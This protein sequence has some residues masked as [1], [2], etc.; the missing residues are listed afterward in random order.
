WYQCDHLGTPMELT[1]E[2][3]DIA[4]SGVY[5]A[6][7]LAKE[8]RSETAKRADIRNPLRFQGQYFDVE[9]GL[10][11]NRYRYYD[12]QVGRFIGKDPIGF[13]GGL[14]VYAYA[15]NPIDWIDPLGLSRVYKDA[16]YHGA[17]D[18]SVKSRAPSNG[19]A[20]LDNSIQ[21][22][23]SSPRRVGVD[24]KNNELVVLDRTQTLPNDDEEFHGHVRCWC[25]LHTD[26]QNALKRAQQVTS[27]GKIRR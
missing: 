6:W 8:Q 4:W 24:V 5:K 21:V 11:Y 15:P 3:G 12:P 2:H 14:N 10:H 23:D 16:P 19:Q 27:K 22:K 25:D 26:Q 17:A 20:A 18:N 7:G 13:T 9:T 1:D